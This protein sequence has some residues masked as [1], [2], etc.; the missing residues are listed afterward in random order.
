[1]SIG[2]DR[3]NKM[4]EERYRNGEEKGDG[5]SRAGRIIG[6]I[7]LVSVSLGLGVFTFLQFF[8]DSPPIDVISRPP[9]RSSQGGL[10]DTVDVE[11]ERTMQVTL[12]FPGRDPLELERED[13]IVPFEREPAAIAR[14]VVN[15][16][17]K[18]PADYGLSPVVGPGAALRTV[19]IRG[20]VVY[21]DFSRTIVDSVGRSTL[22]EIQLVKSL[23]RTLYQTLPEVRSIRFLVNGKEAQTFNRDDG[24]LDISVSYPIIFKG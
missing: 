10:V 5:I 11:K 14:I 7:V 8:S 16:I 23:C 6:T 20:D 15:E 9:A 24:H 12:F 3:L 18:G 19:F 22:S 2:R 4:D 13:R 21:M 1:M 17:L